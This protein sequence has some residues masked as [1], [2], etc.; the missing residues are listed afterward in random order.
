VFEKFS[1]R[2]LVTD[3]TRRSSG[4]MSLSARDQYIGVAFATYVFSV[5]PLIQY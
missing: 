2:Y 5:N 3:T 4:G 1:G